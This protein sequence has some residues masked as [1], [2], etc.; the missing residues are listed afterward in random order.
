M[1]FDSSASLLRGEKKKKRGLKLTFCLIVN[2]NSISN[3]ILNSKST[4]LNSKSNSYEFVPV[5]SPK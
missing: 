2:Q 1:V 4:E 3:L 5:D